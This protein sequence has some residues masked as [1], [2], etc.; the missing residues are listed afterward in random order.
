MTLS[1]MEEQAIRAALE[2]HGG[3]RTH[4]ASELGISL[5]TLRR[6]LRRMEQLGHIDRLR[7]SVVV[8]Q[9]MQHGDATSLAERSG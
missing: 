4:A 9:N 5:R 2:R 3:N 6:R 7:G 1:D 8:L